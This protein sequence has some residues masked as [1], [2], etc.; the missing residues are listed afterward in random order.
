MATKKTVDVKEIE[1]AENIEVKAAPGVKMALPWWESGAYV[2]AGV[3]KFTD[4]I[5]LEICY[6]PYASDESQRM[7]IELHYQGH[8]YTL[9]VSQDTTGKVTYVS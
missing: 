3:L 1:E 8:L 2:L 5:S 7:Y 4:D 9:D 6:S